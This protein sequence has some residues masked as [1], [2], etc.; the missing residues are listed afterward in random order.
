ML[1]SA[2]TRPLKTSGDH[3]GR[4]DSHKV[5]KENRHRELNKA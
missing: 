3:S 2:Q 1:Q 5:K 4:G